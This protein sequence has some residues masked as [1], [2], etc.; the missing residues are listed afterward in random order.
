MACDWNGNSLAFAHNFS[1]WIMA[2]MNNTREEWSVEVCPVCGYN[3]S[4][5]S[6]GNWHCVNCREWEEQTQRDHAKMAQTIIDKLRL[7]YPDASEIRV[8]MKDGRQHIFKQT[9]KMKK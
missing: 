4:W 7:D 8:T 1:I 3:K 9:K 2:L 5:D 6:A